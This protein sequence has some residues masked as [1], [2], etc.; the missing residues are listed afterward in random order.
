[1]KPKTSSTSRV[2]LISGAFW[3]EIQGFSKQSFNSVGIQVGAFTGS[4]AGLSGV[5]INPNPKGPQFESGV[6]DQTPQR[7]QIPFD[8][9]LN[10]SFL[11]NFPSTGSST[12]DL[13]VTLNSNGTQV[14]GSSTS[15]QFELLAGADPY[16]S[17]IDVNIGNQAYLSND[18]RVFTGTPGKNPFPF[19]NGPKFDIDSPAGAYAYIQ[20][21]LTYLNSNPSF[22]NRNGTDPFS[23]LPNQ[24]GE[25]Q[26]D[27]SVTPFTIDV[28]GFPPTVN[29]YNNYNF[30]I[31]RVRLQG[32]AG[33]IGEADN[34]RVFFRLWVTQ[35]I[36]TDYDPNST[37]PSD[38][39][40]A[41]LPG[42]PKV[43]TGDNTIPLFA[44]GDLPSNTDYDPGGPN[45]QKLE[46]PTGQDSLYY[47]FG[48]FLNLY[49]L[50]N[51]ID[52]K[53]VRRRRARLTPCRPPSSP[54]WCCPYRRGKAK[55]VLYPSRPLKSLLR[56]SLAKPQG[57][58]PSRGVMWSAPSPCRFLSRP[59]TKSC[60]PKRSPSPS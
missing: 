3:V 53:Q 11:N 42:S 10:S 56:L 24:T 5:Q 44:T 43:G 47:Y 19:P 27:S 18:L 28:T 34:V 36:D 52:G 9:T 16:F 14:S 40:A 41:G 13:S 2:V 45:I 32:T 38:P 46:I 1:M 4:F 35:T 59:P 58:R 8:I 54:P 22:G 60:P 12:F 31:A 33:P 15:T 50:N 7:I 30:A 48:C 49:D 23:L 55:L 21:L 6:N 51:I 17:N 25:D 29:I 39:D 57:L 37:Y 20:K 26:T